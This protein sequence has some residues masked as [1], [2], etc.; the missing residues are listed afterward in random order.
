MFYRHLLLLFAGFIL[1]PP[2]W[3]QS[4]TQPNHERLRKIRDEI[5]QVEKKIAASKKKESTVLYTIHNIDID[6]DLAQSLILNLSNEQK[7]REREISRIERDL[8]ETKAELERLQG[9]LSKR[10]VTAY[11]HGRVQDIELLLTA[12][13]LND[14]LLWLEYQKRLAENDL[15]NYINI[16][17]KRERIARDKNLLTLELNKKKTALTDRLR[18]EGKLKKKKTKRQNVLYQIRQDASLLKR[19][20]QEKENAAKEI[21]RLI[22]NME[23]NSTPLPMLKPE[24]PF[25]ELKGRMLWPTAGKVVA[26]FG[27]YRHPQLKTITENIGIDI[28]APAGKAVQ[29]V[30]SGKVTVIT[31]QRGRGNILIVSHYGGYYSVY[32]HL[33]E[34][35]VNLMEEVKLGQV[36]GTVGESGSI[37]GPLLHFEIWK[38]TSKLNPELWLAKGP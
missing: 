30:A 33:Q 25:S 6:I 20:L 35:D 7:K 1:V 22:T 21:K 9:L 18:E 13:S 5:R 12:R 36:L 16:K 10:L 19:R 24:T 31:W 27:R 26:R 34:I 11:K 2:G 37:N 14:G 15:R 17:E 28:Q 8:D 29:V 23:R 3:S 4:N 32:T 38:G